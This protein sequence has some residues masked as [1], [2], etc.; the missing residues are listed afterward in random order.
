[1]AYFTGLLQTNL[2][3]KDINQA[4]KW[5]QDFLGF[6]IAADYGTT[7]I[8]AFCG[9]PS[10]DEGKSGTPVLCL[11]ESQGAQA[12]KNTT[13]PVLG[14][15]K[16]HC[17]NLYNEL[18]EDNVEVEE[19]PSHRGHFKFYDPDGNMLEAFCPGIYD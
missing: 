3:V 18:K 14:I 13:H 11:I 10:Y 17:E 7:V 6:T 9:S 2:Y 12:G 16:E 5:Y 19:N 4:A 8:L 1:M 15:S